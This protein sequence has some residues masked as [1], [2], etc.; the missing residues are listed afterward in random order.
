MGMEGV[1]KTGEKSA[2]GEGEG[3]KATIADRSASPET[4][5]GDNV[6]AKEKEK[7]KHLAPVPQTTTGANTGTSNLK[8]KARDDDDEERTKSRKNEEEERVFVRKKGPSPVSA[9]KKEVSPLFGGGG[10]D[11]KEPDMTP[12]KLKL[13]GDQ[14]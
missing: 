12:V 7:D 5:A 10:G 3:G 1:K 14:K 11:K 4:V 2:G 9:G 6:E 13:P 8:R